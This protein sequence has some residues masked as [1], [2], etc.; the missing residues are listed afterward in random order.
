MLSVGE[1]SHDSV[2]I[3]AEDTRAENSQSVSNVTNSVAADRLQ[4]LSLKLKTNRCGMQTYLDIEPLLRVRGHH[5]EPAQTVVYNCLCRSCEPTES[6]VPC[7][8]LPESR[9]LCGPRYQPCLDLAA[10]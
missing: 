8:S 5:L 2:N 3:R 1:Y 10:F 9:S 4:T 7:R 6:D